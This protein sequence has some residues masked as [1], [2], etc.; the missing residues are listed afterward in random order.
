[1]KDGNDR[2]PAKAIPSLDQLDALVAE[3][4][5]WPGLDPD[6]LRHLLFYQCL[7]YGIN[8]ED[9][10]V[11]RLMA[12]ARV[13][14][15]CLH[16][17]VRRQVVVQVARAV[18]RLHREHDIRDGAGCTNGLLP[19][20]LQDPDPSVVSAA[21]CEMAILLPLED[22][23]PLSGPAYVESLIEQLSADDA[24]AGVVGGLLLLGDARVAPL[25]AG[26]WRRLGDEGRQ[27]LALLIQGFRGLHALTVGFLLD[28]LEEEATTPE[29][30]AFGVVAAT[31]ARAGRHAA[32]HGIVEV[33]RTFPVIDAPEEAPFVVVRTWSREDF[34]PRISDRLRRL[35]SVDHPPALV[36]SVLRYWGV[37]EGAHRGG[38]VRDRGTMP[39]GQG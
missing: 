21:A 17:A 34:L 12:L 14:V 6:I 5:A 8:P 1:V 35:A 32:E 20:L 19:F 30:P 16:P 26:A 13:A 10:A 22:G 24:R 7:S 38:G 2:D 15:D 11:P 3:P 29:T 39:G 28:W 31:M 33:V 18:E 4:A 37:A 9:E 36:L 23:D 27:T 25:L